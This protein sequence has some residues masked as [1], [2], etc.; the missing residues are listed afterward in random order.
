MYYLLV[1]AAVALTG[2]GTGPDLARVDMQASELERL[3]DDDIRRVRY[4]VRK[5]E[6]VM[7][8]E[9]VVF[10]KRFESLET[11]KSARA[12]IRIAMRD[13]GKNQSFRSNCFR[14]TP[15]TGNQRVAND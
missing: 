4:N 6:N 11:C 13:A 14:E 1:A 8:A 5:W 10:F 3:S 9:T 15:G 7:N 12:S 2:P